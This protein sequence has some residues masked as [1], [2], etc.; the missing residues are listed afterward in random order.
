MERIINHEPGSGEPPSYE[1]E[2]DAKTRELTATYG[3]FSVLPGPAAGTRIMISGGIN[4]YGT[5]AAIEF[6]TSATGVKQLIEKL[7][8]HGRRTLPEYFQAVIRTGMLRGE[9]FQPSLV[10]ARPLERP[11]PPTG[12][13]SVTK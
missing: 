2:Y 10:L 8:P 11:A 1:P 5:A 3:L 6:L 7:D 12:N 9:S 13:A 4:T